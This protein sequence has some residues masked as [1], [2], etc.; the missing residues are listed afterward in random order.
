MYFLLNVFYAM[1][2][3]SGLNTLVGIDG[4]EVILLL[5]ITRQILCFCSGRF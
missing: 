4:R 3:F 1:F 5:S 2:V